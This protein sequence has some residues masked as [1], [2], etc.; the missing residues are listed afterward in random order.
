MYPYTDFFSEH[1]PEGMEFLNDLDTENEDLRSHLN[2][3]MGTSHNPPNEVPQ[4]DPI[5]IIHKV[6]TYQPMPTLMPYPYVINPIGVL[7]P[8]Y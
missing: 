8:N 5:N 1:E 7:D 6:P 2:A 3:R 4:Q